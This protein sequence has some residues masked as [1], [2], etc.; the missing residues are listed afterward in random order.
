M[1][2]RVSTWVSRSAHV[3]DRQ[4]LSVCLSVCHTSRL[5]SVCFTPPNPAT[6]ALSLCAF[7]T[8]AARGFLKC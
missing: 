4:Y 1:P 8:F 5:A 7:I 2:A 3:T 6:S